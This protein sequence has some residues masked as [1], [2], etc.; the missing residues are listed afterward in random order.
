MD[1][2]S[3]PGDIRRTEGSDSKA[4]A[5]GNKGCPPARR[6]GAAGSFFPA[7]VPRDHISAESGVTVAGLGVSPASGF[8]LRGGPL[9]SV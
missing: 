8:T 7:V 2:T 3:G 1:I 5:R 4:S 6:Q 9:A